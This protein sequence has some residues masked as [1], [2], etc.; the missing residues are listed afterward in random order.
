MLLIPKPTSGAPANHFD[1]IF[2]SGRNISISR[3][4]TLILVGDVVVE[5]LDLDGILILEA[6]EGTSI[7]ARCTRAVRPLA[8]HGRSYV[9]GIYSHL[10]S[11]PLNWDRVS[12]TNDAIYYS[13]RTDSSAQDEPMQEQEQE[14]EKGRT[15]AGSYLFVG[16]TLINPRHVGGTLVTRK[17]AKDPLGI[18]AR[19]TGLFGLCDSSTTTTVAEQ[20][21]EWEGEWEG[22]EVPHSPMQHCF[23]SP[24]LH[25]AALCCASG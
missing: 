5:T 23:F 1:R 14:Q 20:E 3:Q 21:G 12:L 22:G 19:R 13:T 10:W 17:S 15:T 9:A 2:S 11:N 16:H 18:G 25:W 24:L 8:S 7:R 6:V 4:S